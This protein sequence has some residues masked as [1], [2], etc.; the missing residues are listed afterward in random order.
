MR[1]GLALFD[2]NQSAGLFWFGFRFGFAAERNVNGESHLDLLWP[3]IEADLELDERDV[4][5]RG[6][7]S[8]VR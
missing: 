2:P 3:I 5:Q 6:R 1:G 7:V 4:V 8:R